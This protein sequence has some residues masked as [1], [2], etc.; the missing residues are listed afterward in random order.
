MGREVGRDGRSGEK[1]FNGPR[2]ARLATKFLLGL[3]DSCT[4]RNDHTPLQ[5]L[6]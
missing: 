1:R 4:L 6:S 2:L 5:G 3:A